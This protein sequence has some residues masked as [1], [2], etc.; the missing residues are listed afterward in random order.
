MQYNTLR[1]KLVIPE[2]GR[3]IQR[4]VD[5]CKTIEDR[6]ERNDFAQAIISVMGNLNTHLRDIS[7]FHH[8]LWDQL[9][10]M[11]EFDLDVDSPFPIPTREQ[12]MSKPNRVNY[13]SY[14]PRY[15]Y[16]GKNIKKMIDVAISWEEGDE[17]MG[18]VKS[19]ANQMKK[20]YLLWNKDTVDDKVIYKDLKDLSNG[21]LDIE[22]MESESEH[23]INLSSGKDLT[24]GNYQS[25]TRPTRRKPYKKIYKKK[26]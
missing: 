25:R 7:D 22:K 1:K 3:H 21:L 20:S 16:Y 10:I 23:D 11:A 14:I 15:R 5:H 18:L 24:G 12:L 9:F 26:N 17:K 6:D 19:I 13:P 2:Y 8:K 4:M